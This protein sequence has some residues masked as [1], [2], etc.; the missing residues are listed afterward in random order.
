MLSSWHGRYSDRCGACPAVD[1]MAI[2]V[3]LLWSRPFGGRVWLPDAK[4]H[5]EQN[6]IFFAVSQEK[7][8][9]HAYTVL[10]NV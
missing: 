10:R 3:S 1:T 4:G 9:R 5:Q 2:G 7:Y 6:C 8:F